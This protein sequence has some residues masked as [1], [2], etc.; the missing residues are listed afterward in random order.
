MNSRNSFVPCCSSGLSSVAK[1]LLCSCKDVAKLKR[2][3]VKTS[4]VAMVEAVDAFEFVILERCGERVFEYI[5]H[6]YFQ[7][8]CVFVKFSATYTDFD[9]FQR[10]LT[11]FDFV[12]TVFSDESFY[13]LASVG[14]YKSYTT[15]NML[16]IPIN[17]RAC[18]EIMTACVWVSL[19]V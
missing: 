17:Q 1:S 16:F 15:T 10:D 14:W 9:I 2:T 11:D 4:S 8:L 6:I 5:L 12:F 13:R 7:R 19:C 18:V 3:T